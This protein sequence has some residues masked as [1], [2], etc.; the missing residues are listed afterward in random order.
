MKAKKLI[1]GLVAVIALLITIAGALAAVEPTAT[2]SPA[3]PVT[4]NL[5]EPTTFTINVSN[6]DDFDITYQWFVDGLPATEEEL[7]A[8]VAQSS[9][10]EFNAT[11]GKTL[12]NHIVSVV[13]DGLFTSDL[14]HP[15]TVIVQDPQP[16]SL[17]SIT[18]IKV[19][20][21]S[22]GK[23]S[24]SDLND[25]EVEVSN[26][27]NEK[28]EEIVVTVRILDE[29]GDE[30]QE[31]KSKEFTLSA[32]KE[33][34]ETLEFDL[35]DEELEEDEYTIEVEVEGEDN[36]NNDY[37]DSETQTVEVDRENDDITITKAVLEDSQVVCSA[38]ALQTSLDVK[39]KNIGENEQD[40][41]KITVKNTELG[42]NL[43]RTAIDLDDYA[44]S[45]NDYEATFALNLEGAK[46][47]AYTVDVAVYSEDGDLMDT[48]EVELQVECAAN[49][50]PSQE[51][52]DDT[53]Y[54]ADKE[55][56]A[57]LQ[58]KLDEYKALQESQAAY[59]GAFRESNSYVLLLGVLV[60]MMF[61]AAALSVTY[62]LV[63]K[64]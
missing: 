33:N 49:Q 63:K 1:I 3:S 43:Q 12:G 50:T 2:Y 7:K 31:E 53:E 51:E 5:T 10:F 30:L 21:K 8:G 11:N 17:L 18:S 64:R 47:G 38:Q 14:S 61:F 55:L 20:G 41:V 9:T 19:N 16:A 62:L 35:S 58:K 15:W 28:I 56:A 37:F 36:D 23:L 22:T 59:Q 24:L 27:H 57:E 26:D 6:P 29:D 34:E 54:Y 25:I 4:V 44:G 39:I 40:D 13:V 46:T 45:D 48:K 32:G 60:A 52:A 42:L